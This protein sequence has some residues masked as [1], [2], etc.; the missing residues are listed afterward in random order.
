M[1]TYHFDS[2]LIP[3]IPDQ[4]ILERGGWSSDN[5]MKTVYRNTIDIKT[6][7]QTKKINEHFQK[8]ACD[9]V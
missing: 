9:T 1:V 6:V 2:P 5:I 3:V 8:M 4:Y 7:R